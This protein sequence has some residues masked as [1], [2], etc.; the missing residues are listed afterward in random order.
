MESVSK[1]REFWLDKLSLDEHGWMNAIPKSDE[2]AK[3]YADWILF[4]EKSAYD[5]AIAERDE[6]KAK[7]FELEL[8]VGDHSCS[9]VNVVSENAALRERV[10]KLRGALKF[11]AAEENWGGPNDL[12]VIVRALEALS[13][14]DERG[15]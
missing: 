13:Q 3:E 4:I 12:P 1:A 9:V 6:L 11:C 8:H 2:D 15:K 10:E 14:D 7:L 5:A